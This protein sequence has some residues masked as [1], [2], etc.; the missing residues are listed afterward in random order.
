MSN[1]IQFGITD[2]YLKHWG[3]TEALREIFQNFIDYGEYNV[4]VN[5]ATDDGLNSK[6]VISNNWIPENFNFLYLGESYK[7]SDNAIGQYGEGLKMAMLVF[8]RLGYRSA[9]KFKDFYIEGKFVHNNDINVFELVV[10]KIQTFNNN[11]SITFIIPKTDYNNFIDKVIKPIDILHHTIHGDIVDK[12]SG[13]VYVGNLYVTTLKG[14]KRSY[15]F[16]PSL[17]KLDRDRK[18]IPTFDIEWSASL[19]NQNLDKIEAEDLAYSDTR[20]IKTIPK[21]VHKEISVSVTDNGRAIYT[22]PVKTENG[23]EDKVIQSSNLTTYLSTT[24]KFK[25]IIKDKILDLVG[26]VNKRKSTKTNLKDFYEKYNFNWSEKAKIEF[27]QILK[28]IQ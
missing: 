15:N 18:T 23:V 22:V 1:N 26:K 27:E 17:V 11:F 3:I 8:A 5:D 14:F 21:K 13:E 28:Q 6:I 24:Q 20:F 16:L 9:I 10:K 2:N 12:P 4:E 19:I 7:E 25:K